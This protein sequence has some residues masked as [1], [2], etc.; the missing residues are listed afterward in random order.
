[1]TLRVILRNHLFML[2]SNNFVEFWNNVLRYTLEFASHTFTRVNIDMQREDQENSKAKFW[3]KMSWKEKKKRLKTILQINFKGLKQ[4]LNQT[5][6][7]QRKKV[8][9]EWLLYQLKMRKK[10]EEKR[11]AIAVEIKRSTNL[12]SS[13]SQT[14][15]ANIRLKQK[16]QLRSAKWWWHRF[17]KLLNWKT[18]IKDFQLERQRMYARKYWTLSAYE[19]HLNITQRSSLKV[20]I[21][22]SLSRRWK[23]LS[24]L[25]SK[26]RHRS[27]QISYFVFVLILSE[28]DSSKLLARASSLRKHIMSSI[29]EDSSMWKSM[30]WQR[31]IASFICCI[32]L[33]LQRSFKMRQRHVRRFIM[34][35]CFCISLRHFQVSC[36]QDYK[37]DLREEILCVEET[38]CKSEQWSMLELKTNTAW[39]N[40]DV[41]IE[42]TSN[43]DLDS[44]DSW[45]RWERNAAR[46]YDILDKR[47]IRRESRVQSALKKHMTK[48]IKIVARVWDEE[49][50]TAWTQMM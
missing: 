29:T 7:M 32:L 16:D 6:V 14:F 26:A 34:Q 40:H 50:R 13:K 1:M 9:I 43:E 15:K 41:N 21:R 12:K 33:L 42:K 18:C 30:R 31:E 2:T 17:M 44:D 28:I 8:L 4:R 45:R 20:T 48:S 24:L 22:D 3:L 37:R 47:R 49:R 35:S 11:F 27:F 39:S 19:L 23:R 5:Q 46:K 25:L 10:N 38:D 36:A